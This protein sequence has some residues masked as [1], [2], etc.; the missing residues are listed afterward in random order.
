MTFYDYFQK[1]VSTLTL[2]AS[3]EGGGGEKG[4][5]AWAPV[6]FFGFKLLLLDQLSKAYLHLF[7]AHLLTLIRWSHNW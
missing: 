4:L 6:D 7:V 3:R 5:W 2:E 1:Y